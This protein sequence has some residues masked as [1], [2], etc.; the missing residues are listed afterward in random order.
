MQKASETWG[1]ERCMKDIIGC[2]LIVGNL[3]KL[4][5]ICTKDDLGLNSLPFVYGK[6]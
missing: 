4:M 1:E 2:L 5:N 3:K 6:V